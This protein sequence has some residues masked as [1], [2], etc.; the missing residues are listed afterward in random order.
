[1]NLKEKL[2]SVI[3]LLGFKQKFE[4]KS[5]TKDEFNS[6][7]E[8]YQKKYQSTLTG[9]NPCSN[10]RYSRSKGQPLILCHEES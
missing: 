5:L 7:I 1:M 3:E 9:L 8:E 6:L 10:G 2:M 4:D